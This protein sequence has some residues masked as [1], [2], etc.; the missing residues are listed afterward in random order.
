[1][2]EEYLIRAPTALAGRIARVEQSIGS[3]LRGKDVGVRPRSVCLLRAAILLI[4]D[5]PGVGQDHSAQGLARI[6]ACG[7]P[8]ASQWHLRHAAWRHSRVTVSRK[9][10]ESSSAAARSSPFLL[11]DEINRATRAQSALLEAMNERQ[12]NRDGVTYPMAERSWS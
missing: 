11:A 12:M 6:A 9:T 10:G 8:R 2:E 7:F 5:V 3:V 1:M 4:E